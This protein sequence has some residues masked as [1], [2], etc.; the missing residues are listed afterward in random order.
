MTHKFQSKPELNYEFGHTQKWVQ[1]TARKGFAENN[2]FY[3]R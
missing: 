1:Q 3:L 2:V